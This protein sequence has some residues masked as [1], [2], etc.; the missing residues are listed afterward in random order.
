MAVGP[1]RTS[2]VKM[3]IRLPG[4]DRHGPQQAVLT[5]AGGVSPH[6]HGPAQEASTQAPVSQQGESSDTAAV[7]GAVPGPVFLKRRA[8]DSAGQ[9]A[10]NKLKL[11]L[12]P[13]PPLPE[14][15]AISNST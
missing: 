4:A 8:T 13:L 6:R 3:R 5:A 15:A 10:S 14:P 1:A 2:T 7:P 9:P 11:K 12:I